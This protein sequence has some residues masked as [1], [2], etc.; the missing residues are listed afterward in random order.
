MSYSRALNIFK[1]SSI[2]TAQKDTM[3][4]VVITIAGV[5]LVQRLW[6]TYQNWDTNLIKT[7]FHSNLLRM[8]THMPRIGTRITQKIEDE[9]AATTKDIKE[10]I[11]AHRSLKGIFTTLPKEGISRNDVI[12]RLADLNTHY[13]DGKVSGAVYAA[14]ND[15]IT[16]TLKEVWGKT[17]LTNPL[18]SE[19]PTIS[20][21]QAEIISM[22]QHLMRGSSSGHGIMTHGGT[23]S[24]IEACFAYVR[25]AR[26]INGIDRPEIIAP[27]TVHV[28]FDKAAEILNAKLVKVPVDPQTG[29]ADVKAMKKAINDRTCMM[30]GSAPSFSYGVI[31][32][33]E[34]L[35]K[36]AKYYAVPFHVDACLGGFLTA[37]AKD[38]GYELPPC[39]FSVDGVT[40]ISM[41]TH[42]YGQTPKGTSVLLFHPDCN[43]TP[44][45][46]YLDWVGGMYITDSMDG[47]RSGADIATTWTSMVMKGANAYVA[48]ARSIL[49]LKSRL[50]DRLKEVPGLELPYESQTSVIGIRTTDD[51]NPA[52]VA[53]KFQEHGWSVNILQAPDNKVEGF[54]FCLTA[55]HT[56]SPDFVRDFEID[57]T[58]AVEYATRHP[59]EK[60]T[61]IIKAY[62]SLEQGI[63][64]F[65]KRRIG[66]VYARCNNTLPGVNIPGIFTY[67]KSE[68]IEH[69]TSTSL[70][71]K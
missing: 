3:K 58:S 63:P 57:L 40:S 66:E 27:A 64:E 68:E 5:L 25:H 8:M 32:P 67:P 49:L 69:S 59:D 56:K 9:V 13:P 45:Q 61:G 53:H 4:T 24:I 31:D 20:V 60:P 23:T 50:V 2:S 43:I 41:D 14:H 6:R 62:G 35:A 44:T 11:D 36:V 29:A 7:S 18:H 46:T 47:S 34:D 70:K 10:S 65:V 17:Y 33:I 28:A 39:D 71:L 15:K 21:M 22:C 30:V 1:E 16:A 26:E 48:D 12:G 37:F 42:K 51:I 54:H 38:A 55:V 19:W 52:L